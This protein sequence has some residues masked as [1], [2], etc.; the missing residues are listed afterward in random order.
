MNIRKLHTLL[1]ATVAL[2]WATACDSDI[3]KFAKKMNDDR[4][5][6]FLENSEKKQIHSSDSVRNL[7]GEYSKNL[8]IR[9][10]DGIE[11]ICLDTVSVKRNVWCKTYFRNIN[12]LDSTL[13]TTKIDSILT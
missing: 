2:L 12:N 1:F 5:T 11:L 4:V 10:S 8:P 9:F 3:K 6:A 7:V 13:F